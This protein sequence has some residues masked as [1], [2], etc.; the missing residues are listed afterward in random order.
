M[1]QA[2]HDKG[3]KERVLPTQV[4]AE[5]PRLTGW[6]EVVS[7][8]PGAVNARHSQGLLVSFVKETRDM[9]CLSVTLPGLFQKQ[10]RRLV[11]GDQVRFDGHQLVTEDF[12][13]DLLG[14]PTWQGALTR[15]DVKGLSASTVTLL[16]EALLLKGRDGGFLG[17]LRGGEPNNPFVAM[18]MKV[19]SGVHSASSRAAKLKVLSGLV[20]L[21]PGS[22]PS[23]DD[24]IA[25]VLLGDEALNLLR[26]K[27]AKAVADRQETMI[28]WAMEKQDLLDAMSRTNDAGKTLLWQALQGHFPEY[29]IEAARSVSDA[30]GTQEIAD[31]V[32]KAVSR[33]AT[34]GTDALTGFLF[35]VEGRL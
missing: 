17:L 9:T 20:G 5:V 22:T 21:G 30:R 2:G 12:V 35:S 3:A 16:K 24:F 11:P 26:S 34:S 4:G 15:E 7:V 27:E 29:L 25:G 6:G 32:E 18:A 8:F 33:G 23:G 10:K 31:A 14:W 19:L 13:V 28:P 1:D